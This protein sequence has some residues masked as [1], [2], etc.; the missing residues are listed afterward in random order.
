MI[1][2]RIKSGEKLYKNQTIKL[3]RVLIW[4]GRTIHTDCSFDDEE[5]ELVIF[6]FQHTSIFC[7]WIEV[8]EL[9]T[10]C[11]FLTL[12]TVTRQVREVGRVFFDVSLPLTVW[13]PTWVT[14]NVG[15]SA[16]EVRFTLPDQSRPNVELEVIRVWPK[17]TFITSYRF[18]T[19]F[20]F[21]VTLQGPT[22]FW[23]R[24]TYVRWGLINLPVLDSMMVYDVLDFN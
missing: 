7:F 10:S 9:Y 24:R 19:Y 4:I 13:P 17:I 2:N 21:L 14:P 8:N 5:L 12:W 3:Y 16:E 18:C 22:S 11:P 6:S 20:E 15:P 1:I 23:L